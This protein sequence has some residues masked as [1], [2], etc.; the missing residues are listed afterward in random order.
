MKITSF[1]NYYSWCSLNWP[2]SVS[3]TYRRVQKQI[4]QKCDD[5]EM[6]RNGSCLHTSN[7]SPTVRFVHKAGL[8]WSK[9]RLTHTKDICDMASCVLP[10]HLH[11]HPRK[12]GS[13]NGS[14][15]NKAHKNCDSAKKNT[16]KPP[17]SNSPFG[18]SFGCTV[19]P[20]SNIHIHPHTVGIGSVC[21]CV[22]SHPEHT[23]V[24][25]SKRK[26]MVE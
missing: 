15:A 17:S 23:G 11:L 3:L 6:I 9:G 14:L 13:Q 24:A 16:Q 5:A 8:C 21:V 2:R 18:K 1:G 25:P 19:C 20:K 7:F 12:E 22:S 26:I 4:F 10:S